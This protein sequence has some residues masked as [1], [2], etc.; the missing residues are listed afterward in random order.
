MT[1][2]SEKAMRDYLQ[3]N[4]GDRYGKFVYSTDMIGADIEELHREF[5]PYRQ[6]FNLEIENRK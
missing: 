2:G 1:R 5:T 4:R 3:N 6:R